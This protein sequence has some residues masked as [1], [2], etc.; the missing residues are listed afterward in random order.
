MKRIIVVGSTG[1][2]GR[3]TLDILRSHPDEFELV[4]LSCHKNLDLLREQIEEFKPRVVALT[5]GNQPLH[6]DLAIP[7]ASGMEGL[8]RMIRETE[9][10][11]VVNAAAGAAGLLPSLAALESGKD[12]ALANKETMVMAGRLVRET[13]ALH[14]RRIIPVDSE[15][16]AVFHL[17]RLMEP[18]TIDE[19]ILTASGGPFRERALE[20]LERVTVEE[21]LRHPTWNMGR[22]ITVDCATMANKALEVIEAGRF[23]DVPPHRIRVLIHPQSLVH[24]LVRTRDGSLYAQIS[25]PDMR[26]P[27]VNAL[28]H[29]AC[30]VADF[31]ALDLAGRTFEFQPVEE[32]RYPLLGLGYHALQRDGAYPT[33][34]NAANE[35]AVDAFLSGSIGFTAIARV[36]EQTLSADW[37]NLNRTLDDVIFNDTSA[38]AKAAEYC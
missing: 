22:K 36:V 2:I 32:R 23:F 14:K 26:L 5:G 16:S 35:V 15:H 18:E 4:A 9:A 19:I 7:V 8:C 11:M 37:P 27:I 13:A 21:T 17:I 31:A 30:P 24:S 6:I 20:E 33:V 1:S 38:R 10:D 25:R 29:P 34:F 3:Q 28:F 12:L